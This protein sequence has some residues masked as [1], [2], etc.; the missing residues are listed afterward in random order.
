MGS[1][2][3]RKRGSGSLSD[4][5][6]FRFLAPACLLV[7]TACQGPVQGGTTG[8]FAGGDAATVWPSDA[9]D[10]AA[11]AEVFALTQFVV[12]RFTSAYDRQ[13][14]SGVIASIDQCYLE[15]IAPT[16]TPRDV[17]RCLVLDMMAFRIDQ[18]MSGGPAG[19]PRQLPYFQRAVAGR[20]WDRYAPLGNLRRG[21]DAGSF[22]ANGSEVVLQE[23]NRR[24]GQVS[25]S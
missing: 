1:N 25:R 23:Y 3:V 14:M 4:R 18:S 5:R 21:E 11:Q 22:M 16:Q 9:R 19:G 24:R 7:M 15:A 8:S 13:G 17:R 2:Q 6:Y 20:R 10:G 12:G